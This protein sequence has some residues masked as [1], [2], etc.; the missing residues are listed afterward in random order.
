MTVSPLPDGP[1][2]PHAAALSVA[3]SCALCGPHGCVQ[4]AKGDHSRFAPPDGLLVM[5]LKG[6]HAQLGTAFIA[7][8]ADSDYGCVLCVIDCTACKAVNLIPVVKWDGRVCE[9]LLWACPASGTL[10]RCYPIE[11]GQQLC[12]TGSD[13]SQ[14]LNRVQ[15][16]LNFTLFHGLNRT[17]KLLSSTFPVQGAAKARV[18]RGLA[19]TR[20]SAAKA[21]VER[22]LATTRYSAAKARMERGLATTRYSAAKA[23][24]ERGLATTRY[25]AAKARMERGLATTRYSAAK[26]RVERGLATTRYSA[27]E[28]RVVAEERG[29]EIGLATTHQRK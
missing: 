15:C 24:V 23:R 26:A 11:E 7:H 19:T 29:L 20:Y 4:P 28:A 21:R 10:C 14:T 6:L 27:A 1:L 18:E 8:T 13:E 5:C 12:F 22:G 2:S 16:Q 17:T 3:R 9:G 25:S